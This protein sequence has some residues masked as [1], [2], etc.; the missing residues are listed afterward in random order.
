MGKAAQ[1]TGKIARS[2]GTVSFAVMCSRVLGLV[3]EQVFAGLFGAGYA[4][5]AFVV[6][7]RIPNLL[8][9]LFGEGALSAAFVAV[10]SDYDVNRGERE[11]WKLASNVLCVLAL[12]LSLVSLAGIYFSEPLVLLM[13]PDFGL[14]PGKIELT[15]R[16][17]AIMFPFLLFVSLAAAVMGILNAKGRFFVPAMASSFFNLGSIVGGVALALLLPRYGQP[18]IVGMAVGTLVGGLLQLAWQLPSLRKTGFSLTLG[19]RARDAGLKRIFRLMIPAIVGLSATQLNIFINTFFASSC[20]QGSVS[21]LNYAFRLVQFPIGVFGVAVSIATLP[22]IA[23]YAASKDTEAIREVYA[24]SML[25]GFC[26]TLPAS[27]G[28]ILLAKPVIS[29]IFQHGAFT[30]YDT[31]RTAEALA[32]YA[33]G[34]FAYSAVKIMVPVFYALDNTKYPVIA[35]FLAVGTNILIIVSTL[36][37]LQHKAIALATSCSMAG[38]FLFLSIVLFRRLEGYNVRYMLGGILKI[39]AAA[40]VMGVWLLWLR[41]VLYGPVLLSTG[42]QAAKLLVAIVSGGLVYGAAV[43]LLRLEEFTSVVTKVRRRIF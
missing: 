6:A 1:D 37:K 7:F 29:L 18:A 36:A 22:V 12:L 20:A 5:D 10:F 32:F 4:Y 21:W 35:S 19:I 41:G 26:L 24:S 30:S 17:T 43:Y 27:V 2:A 39:G 25:M 8:R 23:R 42:S 38:S 15:A 3:R 14:Q 11:T 16:L 13:A 40:L 28:L 33:G 9:D 34:L 31:A